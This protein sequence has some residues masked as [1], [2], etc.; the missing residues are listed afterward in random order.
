ME[1]EEYLEWDICPFQNEKANWKEL[2][3]AE[4]FFQL[5]TSFVKI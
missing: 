3:F 1:I 4:N 2:A 5:Y